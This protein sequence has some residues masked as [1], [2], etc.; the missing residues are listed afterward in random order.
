VVGNTVTAVTNVTGAGPSN[1]HERGSGDKSMTSGIA[2]GSIVCDGALANG[3]N[4]PIDIYRQ[5]NGGA[6]QLVT[7]VNMPNCQAYGG[8][9][10]PAQAISGLTLDAIA[11]GGTTLVN[12]IIRRGATQLDDDQKGI[13]TFEAPFTRF[14]GGDVSICGTGDANRFSFDNRSGAQPANAAP[15]SAQKGSFVEYFSMYQSGNSAP[16][17]DFSGLNSALNN[18]FPAG[19][20]TNYAGNTPGSCSGGIDTTSDFVGATVINL[21]NN[22]TIAA[23]SFSTKQTYYVNGSV[24]ITGSIGTGGANKTST[25]F[26]PETFPVVLIYA[27]GNIN[28]ASNVSEI[29]AVLVAG[30]SINTCTAVNGAAINAQNYE[31]SPPNG[32]KNPLKITGAVAAPTVNLQR[33]IGTRL[34]ADAPSTTTVN[35]GNGTAA[36]IIEYPWYL[37]F[38][39]FNLADTSDSKFNAYFSVPPRL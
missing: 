11:T 4:V 21:P 8:Y 23:S 30:G 10:S 19:L 3:A 17:A 33:A 36:E 37:S 35:G 38:V 39:T 32:C 6:L 12:T 20:D 16:N 14:F 31:L 13:L 34:L 26:N 28:I 22:S 24:T 18:G 9:T 5:I 2:N 27:T 29:E 15:I 1:T 25:P 7:T